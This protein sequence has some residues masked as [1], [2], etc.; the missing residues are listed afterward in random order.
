MRAIP[1]LPARDWH[2]AA[3]LDFA[4]VTADSRRVKDGYLFAALP[5]SRAD[6]RLF[7]ADAVARGAAAVLAPEG[8][9]WPDTVPARPLILDP[10]PRRRLAQIA[11]ALAGAQPDLVVA[12]TGTNGKTST[13]EFLRQIWAASG[14]Q[15]ASLG[16]LGLHAPGFPPGPGL[17]TP[18][19]ETLADTL[20]RLARAGVQHAAMEASS[21]GL[22]Q[23][24]LDG[25]HLAAGAFTNLTRDHLDYHGTLD[26]YRAAKLRLFRDLLAPGAPAVASGTLD[27]ATLAALREIAAARRLGLQVVGEGGDSIRLLRTVP[28]PDGQVIEIETSGAR[29]E[30]TLA[31]PGRF[32]TDNVLVAAAL[33]QATGTRDVL[34]VLPRLT[35]VRGRMELAARL[36]NGAAVYVDY[37]HTPDALERLLSALR[38]HTHARLHVVFGAGGDRDR[39]K[40]PLMGEAAARLA[41]VAVVTDDNPRSEDPATIRAEVLAGCRAAGN[42]RG[43]DGGERRAAIASALS[44]LGPDDVLVVAGKGHEQGQTIAGMTLPFDDAETVRHLL[45]TASPRGQE[46]A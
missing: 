5:G 17:T 26:A 25:V 36:A 22:D 14:Q 10:E 23:F 1:D 12:V 30:I 2:D 9:A 28:L 31:L 41:D 20:A 27:A 37:A 35:G 24:R 6:G 38:P 44:D 29:H 32:Q 4:G 13:V 45:G 46:E 18:D 16:T 15:A 42:G 39:G 8:T 40:R 33:A 3:G 21:H 43:R 19:P 11:A 7:I 34:A